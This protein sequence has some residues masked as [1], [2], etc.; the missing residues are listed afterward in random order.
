MCHPLTRPG[1]VSFDALEGRMHNLHW[2]RALCNPDGDTPC[3]YGNRCV[4]REIESCRC[5]DCYDLRQP[6]NAELAEWVPKDPDCKVGV[7][8]NDKFLTI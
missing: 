1:N 4:A 8:N 6:V 3:C 7:H 2:F 5:D